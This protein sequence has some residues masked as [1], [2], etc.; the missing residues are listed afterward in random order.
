MSIARG[1]EVHRQATH[2][3]RN[4]RLPT[5]RREA[6]GKQPLPRRQISRNGLTYLIMIEIKLLGLIRCVSPE[7]VP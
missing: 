6:C 3:P 1:F 2:S 5:W 4:R 7:D